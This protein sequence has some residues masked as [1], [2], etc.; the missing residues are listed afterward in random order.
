MP[1]KDA[2]HKLFV[3]KD[4]AASKLSVRKPKLLLLFIRQRLFEVHDRHA[5]SG[6]LTSQVLKLRDHGRPVDL[7]RIGPNENR[8][9]ALFVEPIPLNLQLRMGLP[10]KPAALQ[11]QRRVVGRPVLLEFFLVAT[12]G[13]LRGDL[14][15]LQRRLDIDLRLVGDHELLGPM[16]DPRV[17]RHGRRRLAH[18]GAA[19]VPRRPATWRPHREG[20]GAAAGAEAQGAGAQGSERQGLA[21]NECHIGA[22]RQPRA[23]CAGPRGRRRREREPARQRPGAEGAAL[24][25]E[26]EARA[27]L[28]QSR[29]RN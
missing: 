2:R 20:R 21:S 19:G 17:G 28:K 26:W 27:M 24:R 9:T 7:C 15:R 12:V 4:R 25:T 1:R 6:A 18:G 11:T 5:P 29:H 16:S 10:L 13:A 14:G 8:L 23:G 3:S 22:L